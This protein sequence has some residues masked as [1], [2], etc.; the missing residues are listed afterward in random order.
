MGWGKGWRVMISLCEWHSNS[1]CGKG[2]QRVM[3]PETA[4]TLDRT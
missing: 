3:T 2:G 4:C 1:P